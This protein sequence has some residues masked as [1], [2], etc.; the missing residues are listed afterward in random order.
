MIDLIHALHDIKYAIT[1]AGVLVAFLFDRKLGPSEDDLPLRF[2]ILL[3]APIIVAVFYAQR[4]PAD[5]RTDKLPYIF[6]AL[7]VAILIY[8]TIWS[9]FG[10]KKEFTVTRPW[11]KPW[12]KD[13]TYPT[14]RVMG[15][16]LKNDAKAAINAEKARGQKITV[17]IYFEGTPYDQ[18]V[19]WTRGSRASLQATVVLVYI[20]VVFFYTLTIAVAVI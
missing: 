10:Y 16:A 14:R 12:G 1:A 19:V 7:I 20:L 3:A 13:Y 2:K 5:Q 17:Q 4:F 18:D 6:G 11:W 9:L 8:M 15:G